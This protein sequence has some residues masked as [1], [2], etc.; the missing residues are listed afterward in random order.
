M[1]MAL[2]LDLEEIEIIGDLDRIRDQAKGFRVGLIRVEEY[3]KTRQLKPMVVDLLLMVMKN[4]AGGDVLVL[5]RKPLKY[6]R[7]TD[8]KTDEKFPLYM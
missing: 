3:F 6:L 2:V 4:I 8:E 1:N 5:L 7:L